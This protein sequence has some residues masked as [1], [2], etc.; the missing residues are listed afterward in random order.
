MTLSLGFIC[1][2]GAFW[3]CSFT[4]FCAVE[5]LRWAI[6]ID[7]HNIKVVFLYFFALILLVTISCQ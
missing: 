2:C 1:L 3:S 4:W 5:E 7:I 6:D